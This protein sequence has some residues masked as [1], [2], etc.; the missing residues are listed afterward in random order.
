M[1]ILQTVEGFVPENMIENIKKHGVGEGE[2]SIHF[3]SIYLRIDFDVE[4]AG[5]FDLL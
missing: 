3:K 1:Q 5:I 4:I 2:I